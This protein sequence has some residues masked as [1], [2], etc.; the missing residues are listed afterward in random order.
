LEAALELKAK[1]LEVFRDSLLIICQV[2]GEWQ[3]KDE[4][5]NLYQ[6][7]LLRLANEFKEIKFTHISRDKNQFVDVLAT[8]ASMTQVDA[9]SKIQPID[10]EVRSLQAHCCLIEE[11]PDGKPWYNDIKKFLQH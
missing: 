2:K 10:I 4:K 1:K 9:K 6:N 11:S 8:L 5:L 3:T 7:Y